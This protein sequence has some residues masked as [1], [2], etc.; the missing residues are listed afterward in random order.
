MDKF[1]IIKCENVE[2]FQKECNE[3]MKQSYKLYGYPK[4]LFDNEK[5]KMIYHQAFILIHDNYSW[6]DWE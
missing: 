6:K 3:I 5:K 1:K 2:E 4:V